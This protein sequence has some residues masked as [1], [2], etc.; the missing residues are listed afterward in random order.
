[1]IKT[2]EWLKEQRKILNLTQKELAEKAGIN[3]FTIENIEQ[4]KRLGSV[5]TWNKL[6]TFFNEKNINSNI[7]ISYA[8]EELIN[9]LKQDVFEFGEDHP[10]LIIYKVLNGNIIFTNYDFIVDEKPF[11][12]EK[13][14][15][16]DEKFIETTLKYALEVFDDQNKIL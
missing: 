16:K 15:Q 2:K 11:N 3:R 13:E 5:D 4:G 7:E 9:E 1:M 6:E 8:N 14:L 10:C 12:P